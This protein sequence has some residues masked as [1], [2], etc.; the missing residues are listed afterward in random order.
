VRPPASL[1]F[2]AC[3]ACW[4]RPCPSDYDPEIAKIPGVAA[5]SG[6][7]INFAA[8]ENDESVLSAGWEPNS[9]RSI[10]AK[11]ASC[12]EHMTDAAL[13]TVLR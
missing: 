1:R 6:Q 11:P 3:P 7:L 4:K 8:T 2:C 9:P 12:A 5:V 10:S 13:D